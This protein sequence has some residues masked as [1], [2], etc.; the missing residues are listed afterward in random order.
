MSWIRRL[1][2]LTTAAFV[3]APTMDAVENVFVL[4]FRD[5]H[6]DR[7]NFL[8][9]SCTLGKMVF[10]TAGWCGLTVILVIWAIDAV[11]GG[12]TSKRNIWAGS[13]D[14]D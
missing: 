11:S 3:L 10:F 4:A 1:G 14:P 13:R 2:R 7:L 12:R 8:Q 6:P 5:R 9:S